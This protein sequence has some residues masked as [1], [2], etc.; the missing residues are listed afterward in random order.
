MSFL[1][2]VTLDAAARDVSCCN[3]ARG[4]QVIYHN[5]GFYLNQTVC[6]SCS[7]FG[8]SRSE[9]RANR[10]TWEAFEKIL[11]QTYGDRIA[12]VSLLL[13][14]CQNYKNTGLPL[15]A[16]HFEDVRRTAE[17]ARQ[18]WKDVMRT[19]KDIRFFS[20]FDVSGDSTLD[21]SRETS[22]S[23]G[24]DASSS[25][26]VELDDADP[27]IKV[28]KSD[29][30]Q[31]AFDRRKIRD[32]IAL[33]EF[34][35]KPSYEDINKVIRLLIRDLKDLKLHEISTRMLDRRI[36]RYLSPMGY[37]MIM[38]D[39]YHEIMGVQKGP[40]FQ[41]ELDLRSFASALEYVRRQQ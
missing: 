9:K 29:G 1:P 30:G 32:K 8:M 3:P 28:I 16:G 6:C 37:E 19:V 26:D 25:L 11:A 22:V 41:D 38:P 23:D 27:I 17:D 13:T 2:S 33:T 10:Q 4:D 18:H 14:G 7:C 31:E 39:G 15:E 35:K 5:G 34:N 24:V 12:Q 21:A 20:A 40:M 36:A